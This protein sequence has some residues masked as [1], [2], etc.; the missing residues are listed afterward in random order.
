MNTFK[1]DQKYLKIFE[2]WCWRRIE[3]ISRTDRERNEEIL[4]SVKK[5]RKNLNTIKIR[6]AEYI[7]YIL[8]RN[9][10][11]QQLLKEIISDGKTRKKRGDN[12]TLKE[13]TLDCNL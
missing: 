9:C 12:F 11:L 1:V 10:L 3:K 2:M 13:V 8:R 4:R 5:E 6:K 7:G